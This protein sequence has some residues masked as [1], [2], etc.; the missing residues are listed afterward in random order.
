MAREI[1][2]A[3]G[4]AL[5]FAAE[6]PLA[7]ARP[8]FGRAASAMGYILVGLRIVF[9]AFPGS[10]SPGSI[11]PGLDLALL[12]GAIACGFLLCW[13]VFL[14]IGVERRR[15]GLGPERAVRTG[16]YGLCRHPGFWCMS[17]L[18]LFLSL[19][20]GIRRSL[21]SASILIGLDFILILIQDFYSFPKVFTDYE[22]YKKQVPFL[23][24]R[25]RK[26]SGSGQA[27]RDQGGGR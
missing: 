17:L 3:A 13:T 25:I 23:L 22:A 7:R 16:S 21:A 26:P 5:L 12:L 11:S 6:T 9:L 2:A 27:E 18:V 19:R 10:E 14:E 4:F 20:D 15:H 24:P 8:R 1:M